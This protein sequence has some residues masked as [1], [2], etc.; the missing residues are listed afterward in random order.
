MKGKVNEVDSN[1]RD[2]ISEIIL[3]VN[4]KKEEIPA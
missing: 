1:R 4:D 3:I 2:N